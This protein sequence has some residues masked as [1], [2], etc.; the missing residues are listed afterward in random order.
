MSIKKKFPKK[1]K[2]KFSTSWG[3]FSKTKNNETDT[4]INASSSPE[5]QINTFLLMNMIGGV[6]LS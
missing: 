5:A 4:N 6:P 2:D 1:I 3:Y